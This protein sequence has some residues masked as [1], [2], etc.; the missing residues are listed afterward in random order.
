MTPFRFS[1]ITKREYLKSVGSHVCNKSTL[2]IKI[3]MTAIIMV[4][5]E[6]MEI[7]SIDWTLHVVEG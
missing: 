3:L 1:K 5:A 7:E 6:Q 4:Q 2:A